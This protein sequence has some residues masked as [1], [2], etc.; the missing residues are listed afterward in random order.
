LISFLVNLLKKYIDIELLVKP[1]IHYLGIYVRKFRSPFY[2]TLAVG[3]LGVIG[4]T[5]LLSLAKIDVKTS[6]YDLAIQK[7]L[8]GPSASSE[9]VIIDIDEK[10]IAEL[11]PKFGRWPWSR[12]LMAE[13]IAGLG[14]HKP[15]VIFMNMLISE[16]D[17]QNKQ[18]DATF[19]EVLKMQENVVMPWVRLNSKNDSQS[20]FKVQDIPG[21]SSL[22]DQ[23]ADIS[24]NNIETIALI[25]SLFSDAKNH[26]GFSN[27]SED[28]D[29]LIRQFKVRHSVYGGSV[30]SAALIAAQLHTNKTLENIPDSVYINWRN[31]RNAYE[32]ISLSDFYKQ[33]QG[34]EVA[35]SDA[36]I[37]G[38]IFLIGVSAPGLANLKPTSSSSLM[39]DNELMATVIDDL[40]NDTHLRLMPVWLDKL[41]SVILIILF[42]LAFVVGSFFWKINTLVGVVQ[43]GLAVITLGFVSYTNYFVDLTE[44]IAFSLSYFGF[45]KIHQSIDERAS[46]AEE[47][48]SFS[49][50]D[51]WIK[52][53]SLILFKSD[54][55]GLNS[56]ARIKR[57]LELT[58]GSNNIYI[59]DN[60]FDG[61]NLLETS[62]KPLKAILIFS[63][64]ASAYDDTTLY[65]YDKKNNRLKIDLTDANLHHQTR[66]IE[67]FGLRL[68][69]EV[70]QK[71]IATDFLELSKAYLKDS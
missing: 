51:E 14:E 45:C 44:C 57:Q 15:S 46:R 54:S 2:I 40:V 22:P 24:K 67:S 17:I 32:R 66:I 4:F 12:E 7:R 6:S 56:L 8:D 19:N 16:P 30:P 43:S 25:P 27:L 26:H 68:T 50:L 64:E 62:L 28:E 41:I 49:E 63:A 39:D 60:V 65:Y 47:L 29:G 9:I 71:N 34:G 23:S 5:L 59:L 3:F 61:S 11:S 36:Q 21:Y 58:L 33:L 52:S 31:K 70:L 42:C 10:S 53:Y 1:Y 48:F 38:K 13:V 55:I 69:D 20:Q 37:K 35:I 18:S